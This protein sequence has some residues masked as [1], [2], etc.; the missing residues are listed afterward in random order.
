MIIE[1]NNMGMI[2]KIHDFDLSFDVLEQF[3]RIDGFL[4]DLFDGIDFVSDFMTS[5]PNKTKASFSESLNMMKIVFM[6]L[7]FPSGLNSWG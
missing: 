4:F 3:G 7:V 6:R 1:F 2:E 5:L